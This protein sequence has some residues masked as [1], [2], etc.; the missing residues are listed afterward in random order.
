MSVWTAD[1][2]GRPFG[3]PHVAVTVNGHPVDVMVD[4]G[5]SQHF[6][7]NAAAWAYDVPSQSF[8]ALATD[9]HGVRFAVRLAAPG[10][11]R[12]PGRPF[13]APEH[14]F[15]LESNAL[16]TTGVL[17]GIAPQLFAP[18]GY[19]TRLD[20]AG[21]RLD[22]T[23][24][25]ERP[26]P[27]ATRG[28]VCAAGP[29][30]RDGWRY[31]VPVRVA[32][33]EAQLL[34]D[35][36]AQSTTLYTSSPLGAALLAHGDG[37]DVQIAGAASVVQMRVLEQIPIEIGGAAFEGRVTVGPGEAHCGEDGLVGFEALRRCRLA[38]AFDSVTVDCSDDVPP[39]HHAPSRPTPPPVVLTAI[40]AEPG[41]GRA[42]DAL[43]PSVSQPLPYRYRS[44]IDA[45]VALS[46]DI[47]EHAHRIEQACQEDGYLEARVR[48][49]L[50]ARRGQEVSVRFTVDE[51]RRFSIARVTVSL[52]GEDGT[53]RLD[54]HELAWLRTQSGRPYRRADVVADAR[55]IADALEATGAQVL[56]A[57]FGRAEHEDDATVDVHFAL[58]LEGSLPTA[59]PRLSPRAPIRPT[60]QR[61]SLAPAERWNRL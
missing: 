29:E 12:V 20:L 18:S 40:D 2:D 41:C 17:G 1:A 46:R 49:P 23:R 28:R 60:S 31:V 16:W 21:G 54:E 38:L 61:T 22:V 13:H 58:S 8:D 35:T 51:G 48:E 10:M 47:G 59:G 11:L 44:A 33:H 30:P 6:L 34:L 5:A 26:W 50:L 57:S 9:A 27:G 19:A 37:R 4:T 39:L 42:A 14:L 32:G 52:V 55:A 7:L 15:L 25:D 53:R 45:Y 36:G 56:E 43:R 3:V 24:A